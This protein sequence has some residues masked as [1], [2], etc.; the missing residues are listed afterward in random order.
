[1]LASFD[2]IYF[3]E[4]SVNTNESNPVF[5]RNYSELLNFHPHLAEIINEPLPFRYTMSFVEKDLPSILIENHKDF[6][7]VVTKDETINDTKNLLNSIDNSRGSCI[8][9]FGSALF[10][11]VKPLLDKYGDTNLIIIC[12]ALPGMMKI[13]MECVDISYVLSHP[14]VR[15][16][17][18]NKNSP[19]RICMHDN[20]Y[21]YLDK[22]TL[23]A[24]NIK[25]YNLNP[26]WYREFKE[27]FGSFLAQVKTN[28]KTLR[29]IGYRVFKNQFENL[30]SI[31]NSNSISVL[32]S[33]FKGKTAIVVAAGPSLSKNINELKHVTDKAVII[34]VDSAVGPLLA[35]GI[36]PHFITTVENGDY[37][38]E[39]LTP[40]IDRISN[41]SLI[42]LSS[43]APAIL[44]NTMFQKRYV[45]S[46]DKDLALLFSR[47]MK[48][49]IL[50][51][52][53]VL[54]G[55]HVAL[56]SAALF[57]C[58]HVI[59]IGLDLSFSGEADHAE[60]TV[61]NWSGLHLESKNLCELD[62]YY[63][64]KVKSL[65]GFVA[66]K[67][68]CELIIRDSSKVNFINST[69][70]GALVAGT[71]NLPLRVAVQKHC[72]N[73]IHDMPL[74]FQKP[75]PYAFIYADLVE[76]QKQN[77]E[78]LSK[79]KV[80]KKA[81]ATVDKYLKNKKLKD[82][83]SH[84]LPDK[85]HAKFR[86]MENLNSELNESGYFDK[87]NLLFAKYAN[88][89]HDHE[90][91]IKDTSNTSES[92][93]I[94]GLNQQKFVQQSRYEIL[95]VY[96]GLIEKQISFFSKM[97]KVQKNQGSERFAVE[98]SELYMTHGYIGKALK[99]LNFSGMKTD[100]SEFLRGCN[101]VRQGAVKEGKLLIENSAE[102]DVTLR[103]KADK[104][105][106]EYIKECLQGGSYLKFM[107]ARVLVI[108]PENKEALKLKQTVE[109]QK[110][111]KD[112]RMAI[113]K[114]RVQFDKQEYFNAMDILE[115]FDDVHETYKLEHLS[116]Y[117]KCLFN[118][119]NETK[120]IQILENEVLINPSMAVLWEDIGN[121]LYSCEDYESAI[122]AYEKC[123][124]ALPKQLDVLR[125][126]GDSY[127][128]KGNIDASIAAYEMV[129]LKNPENTEA[130]KNLEIARKMLK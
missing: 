121:L 88:S 83:S 33:F 4:K 77:K 93:F 42:Y 56:F 125:K 51:M 128:L 43:I 39:K 24:R 26:D 7:S 9:L 27:N 126:I 101:Y 81:S 30:F 19:D 111:L 84:S 110:L 17:C 20:D 95:N 29:S 67:N 55:V 34:A 70:G 91:H 120:G 37:A 15:I 12:E 57:G 79:L 36:T 105:Y 46:Q 53:D 130:E 21:L 16:A 41:S 59:T 25:H 11:S 115:S 18:G 103:P 2:T 23:F 100:Y 61:L 87:L 116:L 68:I 47:I 10:T 78:F 80:Y 114:S 40:Y 86:K 104:F 89:Y 5:D 99:A 60:G 50:Y 3:M 127:L 92:L 109:K 73:Y 45:L 54:A 66:M 52:N 124:N 58:K 28:A 74:P 122:I 129:L 63:G 64:G 82:I 13:A 123:L 69:E 107:V 49:N 112:N 106:L 85:V 108:D 118:T 113:H 62:G 14:N 6:S 32:D 31:V 97:D 38:V 72:R 94:K 96:I 1:L 65:P 71:D 102:K 35:S 98:L 44:K 117:L 48:T 8:C 90:I 22:G 76:I 75:R 119:K